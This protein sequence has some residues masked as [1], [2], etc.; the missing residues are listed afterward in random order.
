MV[1]IV[2]SLNAALSHDLQR[3]AKLC[4]VGLGLMLGTGG[5]AR[6]LWGLYSVHTW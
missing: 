3:L 6:S 4:G 1:Q 5:K 2:P